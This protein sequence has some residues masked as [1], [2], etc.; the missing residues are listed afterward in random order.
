MGGS[1]EPLFG[2][3]SE[4]QRC[5]KNEDEDGIVSGIDQGRPAADFLVIDPGFFYGRRR[6]GWLGDEGAYEAARQ[7][8]QGARTRVGRDRQ[9]GRRNERR[10]QAMIFLT[11]E[12]L[13]RF[14]TYHGFLTITTSSRIIS[15]DIKKQGSCYYIK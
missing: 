15:R 13:T 7:P 10:H 8:S 12:T 11:Y 3:G 5:R 2:G 14:F 9:T 1:G 4:A 6:A